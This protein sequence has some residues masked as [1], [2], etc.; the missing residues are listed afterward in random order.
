MLVLI[1]SDIN[2]Y[3]EV[4]IKLNSN[5]VTPIYQTINSACV[6]ICASEDKLLLP[7]TINMISTGIFME[8]PI[9][10]E[11]QIRSRS[12][13]AMKGIFVLNSP[14]TIDADYRGE[15][16][17]ILYNISDTEFFI[18]TGDRIAQ[19]CLSRVYPIKWKI[20]NELSETNRGT[21]GFGSTGV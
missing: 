1:M 10:Y 20:I 19:M 4:K 2:S 5:V 12:G 18:Q 11:V 16:K 17:V 13:L 8:I 6:D 3:T 14:G 21:G 9:H 15:I 7:K